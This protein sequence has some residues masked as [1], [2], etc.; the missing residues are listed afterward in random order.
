MAVNEYMTQNVILELK[1][2]PLEEELNISSQRRKINANGM[3]YMIYSRSQTFTYTLQ[4][5]QNVGYF[6]KLEGS[7]KM[8]AFVYLVL[9]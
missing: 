7:Y 4:N 3:L 9:I 6:T 5:L 1:K 2:R 8:H